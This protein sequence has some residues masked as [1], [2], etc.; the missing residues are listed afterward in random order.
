M[1]R[2]IKYNRKRFSKA[3]FIDFIA[4]EIQ[5]IEDLLN[6]IKHSPDYDYNVYNITGLLLEDLKLLELELEK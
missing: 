6:T 3:D 1:K 4:I 5:K 2:L